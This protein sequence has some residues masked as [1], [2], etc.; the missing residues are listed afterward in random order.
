MR[1]STVLY[2][3]SALVFY[4]AVVLLRLWWQFLVLPVLG[5]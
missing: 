1:R 5:W 2:C 3:L 4:L